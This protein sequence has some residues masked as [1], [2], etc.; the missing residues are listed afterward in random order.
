MGVADSLKRV[1]FNSSSVESKANHRTEA[2]NYQKF[3][4]GR[5]MDYHSSYADVV[6]KFE[7]NKN[8]KWRGKQK[9]NTID[10]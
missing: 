3:G 8:D 1:L 6:K 10:E 7:S 9:A 4:L 2:N 5:R